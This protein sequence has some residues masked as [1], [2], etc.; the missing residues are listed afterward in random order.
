MIRFRD[1][2]ILVL[3][4][5]GFILSLK[6][7]NEV[8]HYN[9]SKTIVHEIESSNSRTYKLHVTTPPGYSTEENYDVVYYLDAWW[10]EDLVRGAYVLNF[11]S[12]DAKPAILVGIGI[13][14][15]E[16]E[17]NVERNFDYTPSPYDIE[18]MIVSMSIGSAP[19]NTETTGGATAFLTFM[20][21]KVFTLIE[22]KY[23]INGN[24]RGFIGH[25]FGGLFGVFS[26]L[27]QPGVFKNIVLI[28]PSL[29]WNKSELLTEE[30]LG[31]LRELKS[32]TNI[33][34]AVGGA[35]SRMLVNAISVFK[36]KIEAMNLQNINI[37]VK[38]YKREDHQ[39]LLPQAIYDGFDRLYQK[40]I[41][42]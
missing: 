18:K 11:I 13:D 8:Y 39:S 38:M 35:E 25:S 37:S 19:L 23:S 6:G 5:N 40:R 41:N 7:Q 12:H 42:R 17:W 27:T 34:I 20:R 1:A 30:H 24:N 3:V 16:H 2:I 31:V 29:W 28:S 26:L 14:G 33:F 22:S 10:L 15:N 32:E 21:S 4:V 36:A 9:G